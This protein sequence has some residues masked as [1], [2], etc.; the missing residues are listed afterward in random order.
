LLSVK[1]WTHKTNAIGLIAKVGKYNSGTYAHRNMALEFCS[2]L[3]PEFKLYLIQEFERLKTEENKSKS[4][5]WNLHRTLSKI[6]YKI[7]TDAIKENLIPAK[8]SKAQ[9]NYI[10]AQEAD[11]LNVALFG[12]TAKEWREST[13]DSS[14]NIRD[15]ATVQQLIVLS[16]LESVDSMLVSQK[17]DQKDRL[18]KLND[19]ATTPKFMF[20][21]AFTLCILGYYEV[22]QFK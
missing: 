13:G 3:N 16:N 7:H 10:Y 15:I 19:L 14:G 2:W 20:R 21:C 18:Q 9:I 1:R 4:L 11:L 17:L 22:G 5:E 8:I 12:K 6:N